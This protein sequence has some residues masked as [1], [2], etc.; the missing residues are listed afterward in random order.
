MGN[1]ASSL[2]RHKPDYKSGDNF[3]QIFAR[4]LIPELQKEIVYL[5]QEG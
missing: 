5:L 3:S 4:S 2:K 1:K